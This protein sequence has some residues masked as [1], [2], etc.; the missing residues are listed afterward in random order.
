MGVRFRHRTQRIGTGFD[1]TNVLPARLP[2]P[3]RRFAD[4]EGLNAYLDRI[5]DRIQ[6][7]PGVRDVAFT[8]GLPTQGTPFSRS[9]QIADQPPTE[10]AVRPMGGLKTVSPSYFRTLGLRLLNGRALSNNDGRG[11]PLVIVI[12][13]TFARMHFPKD[14]PIG[15]RLLMRATAT[16]GT[17]V[18]NDVAWEVVGVVADEGLSWNGAPEAMM[19]GTREQSPSDYLALAVRTSIDPVRL[20]ES[21]RKAVSTVDRDQALANVQTLDDLNSDPSKRHYPVRP[22]LGRLQP[23]SSG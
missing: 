12:N 20:Q 21:I 1:S 23:R 11:A 5:A 19:Y 18:L 10:R 7:L 13:E 8:Q 15:K 2:I 14:D 17:G 3:S 22:P 9:F 4:P 16:A 6:S